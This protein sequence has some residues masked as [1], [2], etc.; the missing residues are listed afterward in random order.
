MPGP[1][2]FLWF[3]GLGVNGRGGGRREAVRGKPV[4]GRAGALVLQKFLCGGTLPQHTR[5]LCG[6][7]YP[8]QVSALPLDG[9]VLTSR[10]LVGRGE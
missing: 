1:L 2:T 8:S 7:C 10:G 3:S 5:S 4:V 6:W 9:H